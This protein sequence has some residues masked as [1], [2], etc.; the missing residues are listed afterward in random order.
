MTDNFCQDADM[1]FAWVHPLKETETL[2]AVA[3]ASGACN[4]SKP[5]ESADGFGFP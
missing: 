1:P 4:W 2:L 3:R 5:W